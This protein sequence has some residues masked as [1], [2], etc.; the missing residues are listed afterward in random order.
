MEPDEAKGLA[1]SHL[2]RRKR[3]EE[4]E[5]R[6]GRLCRRMQPKHERNPEHVDKRKSRKQF[7]HNRKTILKSHV[8]LCEC[9]QS[10]D[11]VGV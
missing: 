10:A 7:V 3:M 5:R 1:P 6:R 11:T 4:V 8:G 9:V 2:R